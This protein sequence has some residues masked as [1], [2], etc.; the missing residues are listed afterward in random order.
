MAQQGADFAFRSQFWSGEPQSEPQPEPEPDQPPETRT[1]VTLGGPAGMTL[2]VD[3]LTLD[4]VEKPATGG[5]SIAQFSGVVLW[6]AATILARWMHGCAPEVFRGQ[7]VLELGSGS[8]GLPGLTAWR[9][10]AAH[11][12]LSDYIPEL[13]GQLGRNL[14]RC[15]EQAGAGGGGGLE[16]R[17]LD[18]SRVAA[19]G[20]AALGDDCGPGFDLAIGCEVIYE[21]EHAAWVAACLAAFVRP[22]GAAYMIASTAPARPGWSEFKQ[23]I[24]AVGGGAFEVEVVPVQGEGGLPEALHRGVADDYCRHEMLC[25][26]RRAAHGSEGGEGGHHRFPT[27][28]TT[29]DAAVG[30]L[31]PEPEPQPQ[32]EPEPMAAGSERDAA[33]VA[34][35]LGHMPAFG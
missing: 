10:G 21:V 22:G 31:E 6:D 18:W 13:V 26:R 2:E 12:T 4:D 17:T 1:T 3:E 8:T 33:A 11:V 25:A 15:R 35:F 27:L 34:Q 9:L 5:W 16:A 23:Q 20:A 24:A 32:P 19:E 14:A 29:I 30:E 7:R 28:R